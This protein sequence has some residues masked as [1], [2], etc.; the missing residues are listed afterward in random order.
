LTGVLEQVTAP[1]Q[2]RLLG[3]LQVL[4][5]GGPAINPALTDMLADE[6]Q[7][8][9]QALFSLGRLETAVPLL[10]Q[11]GAARLQSQAAREA[12][13]LGMIRLG[14]Q[15]F[16]RGDWLGAEKW[17][18]PLAKAQ[19]R[20]SIRNLLG[21]ISCMMQD[22]ASGILHLQEALRLAGDDPRIHQNL[23]LS[24]T[25]QGDPSEADLC[26]GRFLGTM[27][28]RLPRPPGFIDYHER[29]RFELLKHLGNQKYDQ[30]KWPEALG[31]LEEAQKL[32]PE[33]ADLA[34][35]LFLLQMQAGN[36]GEARKMLGHMQMLKP[37]YPPYELYELDMIEVRT[38]EDLELLVETLHRVIELLAG[39]PAVQDKAVTRAWPMLQYRSDQ[40]TKLMREIRD[41]LRKLPEESRAWYDALR[42]LRSVKRDLRRLRQI[43]RYCVSLS[44]SEATRRRL[45]ALTDELERKIDYCR[46]WEEED[47]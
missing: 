47:Y 29:L 31:Y 13:T 23:A 37:K 12:Q 8:V 18:S 39:D 41:D 2:R 36:R 3:F 4:L 44:V 19:P 30:E 46:R 33:N 43:T 20:A 25:W 14:K 5:K 15:R 24:F 40:L 7:A 17:L 1:G 27:E 32:E 26:W 42:D 35:R 6:E 28:K 34:E 9:I 11:F 38:G 16:D 10:C 22:F 21:C 45:D